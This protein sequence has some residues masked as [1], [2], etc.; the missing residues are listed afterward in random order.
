M[1]SIHMSSISLLPPKG[2]P[3]AIVESCP[4]HKTALFPFHACLHEPKAAYVLG[5]SSKRSSWGGGNAGDQRSQ[6]NTSGKTH[7]KFALWVKQQT[8]L[9]SRWSSLR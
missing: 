1:P 7:S 4:S 6:P 3:S 5:P 8:P 2:P 9:R